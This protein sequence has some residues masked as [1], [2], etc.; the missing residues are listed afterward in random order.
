MP[1]GGGLQIDVPGVRTVVHEKGA[2]NQ[3]VDTASGS[4]SA[5]DGTV[6]HGQRTVVEDA[7]SP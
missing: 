4:L 1:P 6:I 5:R 7:A 3:V 2:R